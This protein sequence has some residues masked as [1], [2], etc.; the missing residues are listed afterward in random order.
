MRVYIC[1]WKIKIEQEPLN[2]EVKK[3]WTGFELHIL[4]FFDKCMGEMIVYYSK[5]LKKFELY[6]NDEKAAN[7]AHIKSKIDKL[8]W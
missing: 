6:P 1:I 8:N 7:D 5:N 2:A 3:T 4:D